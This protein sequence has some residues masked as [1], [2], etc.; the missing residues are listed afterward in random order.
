MSIFTVN[1]PHTMV[2]LSTL[3]MSLA[4]L[5]ANIIV[6]KFP[7]GMTESVALC[8]WPAL[9]SSYGMMFLMA[10]INFFEMAH[11]QPIKTMRWWCYFLAVEM[12][13]HSN[14]LLIFSVFGL[15]FIPQY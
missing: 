10:G 6:G 9:L 5:T 13:V 11:L 2:A 14:V 12:I 15:S 8:L 1:T 3:A 4:L 7:F